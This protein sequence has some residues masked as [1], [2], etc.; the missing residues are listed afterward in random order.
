MAL[1]K[2]DNMQALNR[3]EVLVEP[4]KF[5]LFEKYNL[6]HRIL[7]TCLSS[8]MIAIFSGCVSA[9]LEDVGLETSN[10]SKSTP[11]PI[12]QTV[13]APTSLNSALIDTGISEVEGLPSTSLSSVVALREIGADPV[14]GPNAIVNNEFDVT[15]N[16]RSN[17]QIGLEEIRAKA[18]A[19]GA[20][21]PNIN[22]IPSERGKHFTSDELR[23]K[24]A[25]LRAEAQAAQGLITENEL[26]Q[27]RAQIAVLRRKAGSHYAQ[28]VRQISK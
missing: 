11:L 28:A 2:K 15:S 22:D 19:T 16:S 8:F 27:K 9:S 14:L 4:K 23:L 7:K 20:N 26:I 6:L 17:R 3:S 10:L 21:V 13:S 24:K 12:E 5:M 18:N 25:L 1:F